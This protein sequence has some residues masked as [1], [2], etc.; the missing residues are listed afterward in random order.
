LTNRTSA[1][2]PEWVGRSA[3]PDARVPKTPD[4]ADC[5]T[6]IQFARE[7][8]DRDHLFMDE[9]RIVG[10]RH[11]GRELIDA[12]KDSAQPNRSCAALT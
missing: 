6:Q 4:H 2:D 8:A 3:G 5:Y 9:G 12:P 1:L 11:A 10:T 7:I